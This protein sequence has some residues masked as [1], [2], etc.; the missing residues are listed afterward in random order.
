MTLTLNVCL[1]SSAFR[2]RIFLH[3]TTPV[4]NRIHVC[5]LFEQREDQEKNRLPAFCT[6]I[7]TL[8]ISRRILSA[9]RRISSGSLQSSTQLRLPAG[10]RDSTHVISTVIAT[11]LRCLYFVCNNW[12]VFSFSASLTSHRQRNAPY[13]ENSTAR[14][15][16]KTPPEPVMRTISSLMDFVGAGKIEKTI[17][18][19]NLEDHSSRDTERRPIISLTP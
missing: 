10:Q 2:S 15:R 17:A 12:Y 1:I 16:P 6:M 13:L 7:E 14:A 4:L 8:P 9:A 3:V 18:R 5:I 19:V 11:I